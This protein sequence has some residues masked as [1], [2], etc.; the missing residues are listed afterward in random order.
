MASLLQAIGEIVR[1]ELLQKGPIRLEELDPGSTCKPITI[2]KRGQ[3]VVLKPDIRPEGVCGRPGCQFTFTAP[4]RLFPLFRLDVAG[5]AAVCDYIVFCQENVEGDD[6]V[7]VLLCELKSNNV[8]GSR[9][10]VENGRLLAEY[11]LKMAALHTRLSKV[12]RVEHRGLIFSPKFNVP[13]GSLQKTRCKYEPLPDGFP[14]LPFAYYAGGA[15]YPLAHF[16]V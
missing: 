4:D 12:P 6:R 10:Q 2:N 11:V 3:A 7:F 9:R 14:D 8:G 13:K 5:L 1:P 15:E 16:C